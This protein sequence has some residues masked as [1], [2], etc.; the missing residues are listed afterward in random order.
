MRYETR[1]MTKGTRDM[2]K[3]TRD[4]DEHIDMRHET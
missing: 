1:D 3:E 2:R 4:I